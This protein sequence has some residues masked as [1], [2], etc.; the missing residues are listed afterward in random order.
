VA[1]RRRRRRSLWR[2]LVGHGRWCRRSVSDGMANVN[3][4]GKRTTIFRLGL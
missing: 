4:R 2:A 3:V 1:S